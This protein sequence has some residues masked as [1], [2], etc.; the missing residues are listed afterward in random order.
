MEESI[1][2]LLQS[3]SALLKPIS[4]LTRTKVPH[5]NK[6]VNLSQ[7]FLLRGQTCDI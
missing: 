3:I 1:S 5:T 2:A 6:E 7:K 4:A